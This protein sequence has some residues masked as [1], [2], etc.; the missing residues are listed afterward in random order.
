MADEVRVRAR[1]ISDNPIKVSGDGDILL[2]WPAFWL[3]T[4]GLADLGFW[5]GVAAFFI[6]PIYLGEFLRLVV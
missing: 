5:E 6:W 2:L 4:I 3:F 1:I